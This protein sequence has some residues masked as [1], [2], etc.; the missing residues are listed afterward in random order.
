MS[1]ETLVPSLHSAPAASTLDKWPLW[2]PSTKWANLKLQL[3]GCQ[4]NHSLCFLVETVVV[5]V[6]QLGRGNQGH[7]QGGVPSSHG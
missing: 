6:G 3:G 4:G 5:G 7:V 1:P 2:F